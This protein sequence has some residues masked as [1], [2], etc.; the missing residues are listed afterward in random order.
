MNNRLFYPKQ[1][2]P[3]ILLTHLDT[4]N[5]L[6]IYKIHNTSD[7]SSSKQDLRKPLLEDDQIDSF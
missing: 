4:Q 3:K 5:N 2:Y 1:I 6:N 7:I